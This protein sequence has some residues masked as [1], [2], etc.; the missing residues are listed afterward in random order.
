M[1]VMV[2]KMEVERGERK[3][4]NENGEDELVVSRRETELQRPYGHQSKYKL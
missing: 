3:W 2:R 4:R 1:I